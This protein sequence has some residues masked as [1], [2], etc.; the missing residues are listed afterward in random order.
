MRIGITIFINKDGSLGLF[1]N[2]LRQNVIFLARLLAKRH[3]VFLLNGG[4]SEPAEVPYFLSAIPI[5][6]RVENLDVVI[7]LGAGLSAAEV[8]FY[9]KTAK[10]I[11]YKGGNG[12]VIAMEAVCSKPIR[13]DA[14]PYYDKDFYDMIWMTP[15]HLHTYK[16][17]C[18]TLYRCP[19]VEVPQVWEPLFIPT[20]YGYRPTD[21]FRVGVMEPN[22]TVM[23]TS[24]YPIMVTEYGYRKQ[25][26]LFKA[27]YVTNSIQFAS[28]PHF[29]GFCNAMTVFKNGIATVE[30]RFQGTEFIRDHCDA[31]VTHQWENALNYLYH[32]VLYGNYPLIHNS[33]LMSSYGYY[34]PDFQTE[35]GGKEL[36]RAL[37]RHNHHLAGYARKHKSLFKDLQNLEK[38]LELLQLVVKKE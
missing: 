29:A 10:I 26:E 12:G 7:S 37:K 4:D 35:Q 27:V 17:W 38:H 22:I 5:T 23:K 14:E 16:G 21:K 33:S 30:Q 36:V 11:C 34:Y 32:E 13:A 18:E 24:H 19:V 1:E 15:Q 3:E 9:R 31:V 6:R 2:G 28:D 20:E 8:E 25:P